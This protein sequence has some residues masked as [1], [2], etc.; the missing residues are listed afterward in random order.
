V[1]EA[2]ATSLPRKPLSSRSVIERRA[3]RLC[4]ILERGVRAVDLDQRQ[5]GDDALL[6][7]KLVPELLLQQIPD[8]EKS[9]RF[10]RGLPCSS[11]AVIMLVLPS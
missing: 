5:Q 1:R 8:Q 9:A 6:E 4:R 11:V 10:N 2:A 3:D 7:R